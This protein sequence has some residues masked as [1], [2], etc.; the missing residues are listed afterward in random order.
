MSFITNNFSAMAYA[1]GFTICNYQTDDAMNTVKATGYF[2]EVSQ[3]VRKGD[4]IITN[5]GMNSTLAS[6][7]LFVSDISSG[8]V[9][10]TPL[11][12]PAEVA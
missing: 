2:N 11:Y 3:I 12:I 8:V 7:I 10:V 1:N 5:A 9:T 6:E 4:M